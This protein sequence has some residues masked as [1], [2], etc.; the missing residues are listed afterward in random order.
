MASTN[1]AQVIDTFQ[2]KSVEFS[3]L[4]E[5]VDKVGIIDLER[6]YTPLDKSPYFEPPKSTFSEEFIEFVFVLCMESWREEKKFMSFLS[7]IVA[8]PSYQKIIEMGEKALPLIL[9]QLREEGDDPSHWF[10]ALET[11]TS[12]NPVP[13][14]AYGDMPK[15]AEIW[16][17]WAEEN[18]V[19][20]LSESQF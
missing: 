2:N 20:R 18:N 7:D 12:H 3:F 4:Q 6:N 16:L 10:T 13:E 1:T 15:M 17:Y 9:A 14:S 5:K 8:C 11:I 19:S